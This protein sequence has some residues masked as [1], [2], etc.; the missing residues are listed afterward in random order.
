MTRLSLA[1]FFAAS[2]LGPWAGCDRA[3]VTPPAAPPGERASGEVVAPAEQ[4]SDT[5]GVM[6]LPTTRRL[7]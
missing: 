7:G 2:L 4:P 5:D 6:L 1:T 3:P